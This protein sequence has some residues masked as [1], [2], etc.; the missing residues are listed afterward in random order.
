MPVRVHHASLV[1]AA[2]DGLNLQRRPLLRSHFA[3][4]DATSR[5]RHA[6]SPHALASAHRLGLTSLFGF[7]TSPVVTSCRGT[8][9]GCASRLPPPQASVV[10]RRSCYPY[11]YLY[12][13]CRFSGW[14]CSSARRIPLYFLCLLH[15]PTSCFSFSLLSTYYAQALPHGVAFLASTLFAFFFHRLFYRRLQQQ[16]MMKMKKSSTTTMTTP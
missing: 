15:A 6:S 4:R 16:M 7:L 11:L 5:R 3:L 13:V 2:L 8:A 9:P 1:P 12:L 14:T 10:L